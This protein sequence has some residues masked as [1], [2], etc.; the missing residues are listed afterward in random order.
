MTQI[1]ERPPATATTPEPQAAA[2]H[3]GADDDR[4]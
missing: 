4:R 1:I 3:P 2:V